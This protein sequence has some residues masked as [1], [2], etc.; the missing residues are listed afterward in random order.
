MTLN[1]SRQ[2]DQKAEELKLGWLGGAERVNFGKNMS[3][4]TSSVTVSCPPRLLLLAKLLAKHRPSVVEG[5]PIRE[6]EQAAG[7]N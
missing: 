1:A 5:Q 7:H 3:A 4:V 6:G 2:A